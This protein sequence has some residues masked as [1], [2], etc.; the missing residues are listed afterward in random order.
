MVITECIS[1]LNAPTLEEL[2][3]VAGALGTTEVLI[4]KD[5][6][7]VQVLALIAGIKFNGVTTVF[8]GGTSLSKAHNIIRRFSEDIDFRCAQHETAGMSGGQLKKIRRIY[9]EHIIASLGRAGYRVIDRK[10]R[11]SYKS[12]IL[13]IEYPSIVAQK[14]DAGLRPDIQLEMSFHPI[15]LAAIVKPI[16]SFVGQNRQ[17]APEAP[18]ISCTDPVETG[19]D[20]LA[21]LVWRLT[22]AH[23]EKRA[24][25]YKPEL[26]RHVHDLAALETRLMEREADF[27]SLA[28]QRIQS[29]MERGDLEDVGGVAQVITT[30]LAAIEVRD[31]LPKDY[32]TFVDNYVFAPEGE[33][34]KYPEARDAVIRLSRRVLASIEYRK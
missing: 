31:F 18:A 20:K 28:A 26:M 33:R 34:I 29:D 1:S 14:A 19:A 23:L 21:A 8:S 5:W 6:H 24:D 16:S 12:F 27:L 15:S 7:V 9:F 22:S 11:D 10:V 32:Q 4:E 17:A 2:G 25:V 3:A 13:D 30:F